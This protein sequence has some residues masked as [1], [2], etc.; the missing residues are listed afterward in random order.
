M[1]RTT[2]ARLAGL[3][4]LLYI[5]LAL[6]AMVL[7]GRATSG[8]GPAARLARI[9]QHA[10]DVRVSAVLTL[11][12][13]FVALVLAV[14]LYGITRD[15]D[16]ELAVLALACRVGEGVLNGILALATVGLL[17]LATTGAGAGALDAAAV[18]TLGALLLRARGWTETI[19][20]TFFA[21]GST[22]FSWLLLRGRLVPFPLAWLGVLASVLLVV[23]LPLQL[24]GLLRG[25]IT[26]IMWLPMGAFE[27][28]LGLW[29]LIKGVGA[30]R[31]DG[32]A[33]PAGTRHALD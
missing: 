1:T 6:P 31:R 32:A 3:T 18:N 7:M 11:V 9:A 22:L 10:A 20:A 17:W 26:E 27:V 33:S 13:A 14:A 15:E 16:H 23:A 25:M 24:A 21:V 29:L 28:L 5:A 12:T 30:P 4:Y 2:N 19:G 8:E